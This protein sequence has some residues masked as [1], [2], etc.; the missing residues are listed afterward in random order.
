M[1]VIKGTERRGSSDSTGDGKSANSLE[2]GRTVHSKAV[3]YISGTLTQVRYSYDQYRSCASKRGSR[4]NFFLGERRAEP[5]S[6]VLRLV[7]KEACSNEPTQAPGTGGVKVHLSSSLP[8]THA[9][10]VPNLHAA[11]LFAV[12]S[13]SSLSILLV[14]FLSLEPSCTPCGWNMPEKLSHAVMPLLLLCPST[15]C[16][17]PSHKCRY[18]Y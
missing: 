12:S 17:K 14:M 11:F 18:P 4:R 7:D 3:A 10:Q 1:G 16:S 6:S 9:H 13:W 15:A 8:A 2:R 5:V